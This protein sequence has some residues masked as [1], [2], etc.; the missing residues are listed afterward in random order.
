MRA[1]ERGVCVREEVRKEEF[2]SEIK[3]NEKTM[4]ECNLE[5]KRNEEKARERVCVCV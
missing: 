1:R 4:C 3:R 2:E 5:R